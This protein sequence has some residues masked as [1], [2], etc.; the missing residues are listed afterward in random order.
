M[1]VSLAWTVQKS[2]NITEMHPQKEEMYP[3]KVMLIFDPNKL[4]FQPTM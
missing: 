3:K 4:L 2:I 1:Y